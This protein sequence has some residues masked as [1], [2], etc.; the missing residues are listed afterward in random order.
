MY[1]NKLTTK[2]VKPGVLK[3]F[4]DEKKKYI[5]MEMMENC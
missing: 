3:L 4:F 5:M 2:N 1:L